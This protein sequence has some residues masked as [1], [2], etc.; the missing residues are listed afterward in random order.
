MIKV[1][2]KFMKKEASQ[3][4][5]QMNSMKEDTETFLKNIQTDQLCQI[6]ICA[7]GRIG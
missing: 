2:S 4:V 6:R 5:Q 1:V 3:M 7:E